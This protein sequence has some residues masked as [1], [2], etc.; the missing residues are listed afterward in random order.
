MGL[1]NSIA[2]YRR[3]RQTQ[4]AWAYR[5]SFIRKQY[6][7]YPEARDQLLGYVAELRSSL[8]NPQTPLS[9][10]AEW[11]LDIFNG[12]RTDSGIRVSEMTALQTDA[13]LACV[14]IICNGVSSLPLHVFERQVRDGR[15]AKRKAVDHDLYDM[16][17][18]R[19]N[20]EMTSHTFRS[21]M[22]CHMLLWGN[23][24][25]E[26][27]RDLGARPVALWP[28]NPARTRP[29]RTTHDMRIQGTLF[30]KG[31]LVYHTSETMGDEI[32]SV[33]D[34]ANR[35]AV[36]R[37]V[38]AED[39][40]HV[41]G[42]S[43]DGRL[44][45]ST[46][47]L[48]R[49]IIGLA[50]ASEKYGAKFFGNGAVPRGVIELPGVLPPVQLEAFK[51]S[52]AEAHGGEN[53]GK[54]AVLEKGVKFTPIGVD[55]EKS[56]LLATRDHQRSAIASIFNVPGH[57]IGM[58]EASKSTTEQ[59]AIEFLTYCL[60]PWLDAWEQE[61]KVK[62]FPTES[63]R[64]AAFYAKYDVNRL[65]YPDASSR[66]KYYQNGKQWGYLS[67]NDIREMEDLNPVEDGS[68]DIY[69]MGTNMQDAA[70]P[71]TAPHMS[72][73]EFPGVEKSQQPELPTGGAPQN[74]KTPVKGFAG[75][76][77]EKT[78]R[79]KRTALVARYAKAF[80]P[81]FRDAAGRILK[82]DDI[83]KTRFE[84]TFR[85][86]LVSMVESL[87]EELV[88]QG[89]R[90]LGS[91]EFK[92]Q[93]GLYLEGMRFNLQGVKPELD[94]TYAANEVRRA[95][96]TFAGMVEERYNPDHAR[97]PRAEDGKFH[98]G[99][100]PFFIGRHGTTDDDVNKQWSGWLP[101]KLNEK[102]VAEIKANAERLKGLG[103][104]R[105]VSSTLPRALQTAQMYA[106]A[107]GIAVELEPKLNALDLGVFAGKLEDESKL[108]PYIKEPD[109]PIPGG[110]SINGYVSE[111]IG[112][113]NDLRDQNEESGP[114]LAL[115]HSSAIATYL[116]DLNSEKFDLETHDGLLSPAGMVKVEGKKVT[117]VFGKLGKGDAA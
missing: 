115:S 3:Y 32:S 99:K 63:A 10:P 9:F 70:H 8:E 80:Y 20:P 59:T 113:I 23:G 81:L 76:Q 41:P 24:Y 105:I 65:L 46:V 106:T 50:L 107:L 14:K 104:S 15:D 33:D 7:D 96:E 29:V 52:W 69:W 66:S 82:R 116:E 22:Q 85:A 88:E 19:P 102:G 35:I 93:I 28:R 98:D 31:T 109:V 56:Q 51:R 37:I 45:Q 100:K 42:L 5:E 49:Q 75:D 4:A 94:E 108:A 44:G 12:G 117:V 21:V 58:K 110:E 54:T 77:E 11:L 64:N 38:L 1:V 26:I 73:G 40:L 47:Y 53:Q 91:Q 39:M 114:I 48:S 97:Q 62:L 61:L 60:N 74:P 18:L 30:P 34:S 36:E 86:T 83:D 87:S 84:R 103:I 112:A 101:T 68:G 6:R 25:A 27:Q 2:G 111:V 79:V 16:L 43:L 17:R 13:V 78:K 92:A 95:A 57:M 71:I 90:A 89:E 72:G 55:P 67:T